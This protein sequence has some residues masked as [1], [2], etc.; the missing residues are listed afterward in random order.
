MQVICGLIYVCINIQCCLVILPSF[1]PDNFLVV[2]EGGSLANEK[3]GNQNTN[4]MVVSQF[5]DR[6]KGDYGKGMLYILTVK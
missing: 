1:G 5:G 3:C 6:M 2:S 4:L